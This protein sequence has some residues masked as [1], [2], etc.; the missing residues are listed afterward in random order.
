M[1]VKMKSDLLAL[2]AAM[3]QIES[4][5]VWREISLCASDVSRAHRDSR[6]APHAAPRETLSENLVKT[7]AE[8]HTENHP[9]HGEHLSRSE[10]ARLATGWPA[11][12]RVLGGGLLRGMLHE[13]F[14]DDAAP[15]PVSRSEGPGISSGI[16]SG[17]GLGV[18]ISMSM[19][20]GMNGGMGRSEVR[21]RV[22]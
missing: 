13:W 3:Q 21:C 5:A 12:D 4:R 1:K 9:G 7:L 20:G 2:T 8:T 18:G 6:M 10:A 17:I 11:I 16:D 22:P 15:A 19:G 14:A